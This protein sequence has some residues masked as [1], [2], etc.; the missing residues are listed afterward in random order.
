MDSASSVCNLA[1][2]ESLSENSIDEMASSWN[3]FCVATEVLL[4]G[5]GDL[6]HASE[7]SS[8]VRNLCRSGLESLVVEHFFCSI[9]VHDSVTCALNL[10]SNFSSYF[11]M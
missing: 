2:L 1:I 8:Y 9:E 6:S 3:A 7:F 11:G 10:F 4:M 5:A